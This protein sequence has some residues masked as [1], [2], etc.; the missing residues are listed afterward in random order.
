MA[1]G[2]PRVP[3]R[4]GS[5]GLSRATVDKKQ[6]QVRN[7]LNNR[8]SNK[9][10]ATKNTVN[11]LRNNNLAKTNNAA[12][13]KNDPR[14]PRPGKLPGPGLGK[15]KTHGPV[16]PATKQSLAKQLQ[17]SQNPNAQKLGQTLNKPGHPWTKNNWNTL[18]NLNLTNINITKNIFVVQ[19]NCINTLFGSGVLVGFGFRPWWVDGGGLV[20]WL[21][22][23]GGDEGAC[24]CAMLYPGGGGD[25][26]D[27]DVIFADQSGDCSYPAPPG[28][29]PDVPALAIYDNPADRTG[30]VM[31][32]SLDPGTLT[33]CPPVGDDDTPL[34]DEQA[35]AVWQTTRFLRV[36]NSTNKPVTMKVYYF[37]KVQDA[38]YS[39]FPADPDAPDAQCVTYDLNP[40]EVCDLQD[41]DWKL[42]ATKVRIEAESEGRKWTRFS[43]NDLWLVPETD[44]QGNHGYVAPDI[45]VFTFTLG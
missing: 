19:N 21:A 36:A 14:T 45:E 31:F 12:R 38:D 40:G 22:G 20:G 7:N 32:A 6:D 10:A 5:G 28:I 35:S 33:N 34:S 42:N 41:N 3:K 24:G 11:R 17:K 2:G 27:G 44:D 30:P 23:P 4:S 43:K 37:T 29:D 25:D 9:P 18:N 26:G 15:G 8:I 1:G 13:P 16:S 39:W